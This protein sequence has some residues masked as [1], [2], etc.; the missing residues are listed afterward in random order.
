[1][2]V[3]GKRELLASVTETIFGYH[4]LPH[5]RDCIPH[6]CCAHAGRPLGLSATP[7]GTTAVRCGLFSACQVFFRRPNLHACGLIH[8]RG[9]LPQARYPPSV[10]G[11]SFNKAEAA[12]LSWERRLSLWINRASAQSQAAIWTAISLKRA[13]SHHGR[14]FPPGGLQAPTAAV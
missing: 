6:A 7:N 4:R 3:R 8:R 11:R 12:H 14:V 9:S 10:C 13:D 5:A 2:Q 1:M